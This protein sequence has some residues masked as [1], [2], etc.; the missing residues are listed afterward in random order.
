MTNYLGNPYEFTNLQ[1]QIRSLPQTPT[2]KPKTSGNGS[3]EC[4][5]ARRKRHH[6][7]T[8]DNYLVAIN[9]QQTAKTDIQPFFLVFDLGK[10]VLQ[11]RSNSACFEWPC[12]VGCWHRIE[13]TMRNNSNMATKQFITIVMLCLGSVLIHVHL[14]MMSKSEPPKIH[15]NSFGA[16]RTHRASDVVLSR[17]KNNLVQE[18]SLFNTLQQIRSAKNI[19]GVERNNSAHLKVQEVD[20]CLAEYERVNVDQLRGITQESLDRS[21]A[22]M[23]NSERL[24]KFARKLKTR[25]EVTN[26]LIMG[27]SISMGHGVVPY[28]EN[29]SSGFYREHLPNWMNKFYPLPNRKKHNVDRMLAHGVDMCHVTKRLSILIA[30]VKKRGY[31]PD[32]IILEFAINDYQGQDDKLQVD[33]KTDVFFD[34]FQDKALCAEIVINKLARTYPD[35]AIMFLEMKTGVMERKTAQTLHL[36]VAQ[37][38]EIPVVSYAEAMFYQY[39]DLISRLNPSDFYTVPIGDGI[40]PYPYGC[41]PCR[42]DGMTQ[43]FHVLMKR[44]TRDQRCRSVCDLLISRDRCFDYKMPKGREPCHLPLFQHDEIHPGA[45]GHKVVADLLI[46]TL[47][48]AVKE[49]C[50]EKEYAKHSLP[51]TGWLSDPPSLLAY[52]DYVFVNDTV[53]T[54]LDWNKLRPTRHTPGWSYYAD[55]WGR[56]GWIATDKFGNESITFDIDLPKH[57]CYSVHLAVLRSY[58]GMGQFQIE[59]RDLKTGVS[60]TL[61]EDGLWEPRISVWSD[62]QVTKDEH[63]GCTGRCE[64]TV[65]TKPIV[66]PVKRRGKNKVKVL[67]LSVRKCIADAK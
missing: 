26:S 56:P 45:I 44:Y 67:T 39:N 53:L 6:V 22:W 18:N 3:G 42:G 65:R 25:K 47:S 23:G 51:T 20:E 40:L 4:F 55:A 66:D 35:A 27:G 57:E 60:T 12:G 62:N 29:N 36:G 17:R 32:L 2:P 5:S 38:Y 43:Q 33:H 63:P 31:I 19:A 61:D 14:I 41:S 11:E 15:E 13:T 28:T 7:D 21:R 49:V 48:N 64:I 54:Y 24:Y 50:E 9:T 16:S 37:H 10:G 58:D 59:T 8:I 46:H 52:A 30:A 1:V 34:G